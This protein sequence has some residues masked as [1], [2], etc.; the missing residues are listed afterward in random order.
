VTTARPGPGAQR[1][2]AGVAL[3]LLSTLC[4]AVLDVTAKLLSTVVPVLILLW[5]RYTT[6]AVAMGTWFV[7][8]RRL[9]LLHAAHP[10]FQMLR[11]GLLLVVSALGFYGLRD[12]PVAEFTAVVM[13]TP[14]IV[15][16]LAAL[17]HGEQVSPRRWA[18][19]A[20]GF[21][22]ALIILRPGSGLFGW[23]ALIP[24]LAALCNAGFQL[25]TRRLAG[26]ENPLTTHFYTG[27]VGSLVCAVGLLLL[28]GAPV[29]ALPRELF[30]A[31]IGL[32]LLL[33][34]MG[35]LGHLLLILAFGQAPIAL[36]API[37]YMQI[38]FAALAGWL[39][40]RHVPDAWAWCGM[41]VV[42]AC[43]AG[44]VWLNARESTPPTHRAVPDSVVAAD[45]MGD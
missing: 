34:A 18:L 26:L 14:V 12:M 40:F 42:A 43:G 31:D 35:T 21:A 33:G 24:A 23:V 9:Q 25:M 37:Q 22:G 38:L 5:A 6:Q 2:L 17:M 10:R 13:L 16:V 19:V 45:T 28:A 32:L 20:G 30:A 8:R 11:G 15:T 39:V 1:P 29:A 44:A 3:I 36:L 27:L 7:V 41:A 4:F